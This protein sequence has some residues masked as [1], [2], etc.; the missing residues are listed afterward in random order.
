MADTIIS[1]VIKTR[2]KKALKNLFGADVDFTVKCQQELDQVLDRYVDDYQ[3]YRK[4][5]V[6]TAYESANNAT[7]SQVDVI[8][9]IDSEIN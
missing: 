5:L 3:M 6:E 8:L 7:K 9:G 4:N 1:L 2:H